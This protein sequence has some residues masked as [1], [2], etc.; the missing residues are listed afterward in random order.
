M[1]RRA[2]DEVR[3]ASPQVAVTSIECAIPEELLAGLALRGDEA[4]QRDGRMPI[5]E[6]VFKRA[7]KRLR[8]HFARCG[9]RP[10]T[11]HSARHTWATLALRTGKSLR[12]I[13][14]Q[15]GHSDPAITLRIYAHVLPDE[16]VDLSFLDFET[17]CSASNSVATGKVASVRAIAQRREAA[18]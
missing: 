12:W 2:V 18:E 7:W 6:T 11:L 13:A 4:K 14:D 8:R 9:I 3:A 16:A 15:L 10:L 1:R 17:S 5:G